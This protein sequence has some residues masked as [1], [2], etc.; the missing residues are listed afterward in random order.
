MSSKIIRRGEAPRAEPLDV[1]PIQWRTHSQT[2]AEGGW[3]RRDTE[4]G[5]V[6]PSADSE[7]QREEARAAAY[8]RGFAAGEAAAAQPAQARLEP[9]LAAFQSMVAELAG[10]RMNLR[11]ETEG[12]AVTL[13]LAV[14][15]RVL[16]WEIATDPE[17]ILG[18]VKAAL[19]KC[20]AR[21]TQRLRVSP[22]DAET[23]REHKSSLNLPPALEIL[24]D[25]NLTRGS[26]I[27]ETTRGDLDAS[28]D[29][30]LAEIERGFADLL[31]R[32][33]T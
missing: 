21:E 23:I 7:Q 15:R 1:R 24:A 12:A 27:F 20:D 14:A 2:L 4:P 31:K 3:N 16:Y 9:A 28:V 29:A 8:G 6:T 25:G 19:Q 18:L 13:A 33:R 17:A 30:Q 22:Q 11:A 5:S 32:R 26:A 10:M